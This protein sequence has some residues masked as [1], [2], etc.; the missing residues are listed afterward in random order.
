MDDIISFYILKLLRLI[1]IVIFGLKVVELLLGVFVIVLFGLIGGVG[2]ILGLLF[3]DLVGDWLVII[4]IYSDSLYCIDD[5]F[6]LL[7][8]CWVEV[9][10]IGIRSII[11]YIGFEGVILKVFNFK[12]IDGNIKNLF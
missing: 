7:S 11:I 12:M 10:Y 8:G 9:K 4:I 1:V 2:F 3:K 5:W 6:L